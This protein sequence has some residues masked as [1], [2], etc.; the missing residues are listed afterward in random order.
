MSAWP[1][2]DER[3]GPAWPAR[4]AYVPRLPVRALHRRANGAGRVV[5]LS[6]L[7]MTVAC[8]GGWPSGPAE[9]RMPQLLR[10]PVA[11][12]VIDAGGGVADVRFVDL[13]TDA[14]RDM[15]AWIHGALARG[16]AGAPPT[17]PPVVE[18]VNDA[19]RIARIVGVLAE[20]SAPA[21]VLVDA[22]G[23]RRHSVQ[24]RWDPRGALLVAEPVPAGRARV[25]SF[26][27][28][29][30]YAFE[31]T[32]AAAP[33]QI[34][35][36]RRRQTRRV[37]VP[38]H[39]RVK[40]SGVPWP[41]DRI[42]RTVRDISIGGLGFVTDPVADLVFPGIDLEL[43][44]C[45]RGGTPV[46]CRGIVR[47]V[48]TSPESGVGALCG[49][50][51]LREPG[52]DGWARVVDELLHPTTQWGTA[53]PDDLWKVYEGSGYFEL[54]GKTSDE[55]VD[56]RDSFFTTNAVLSDAPQIGGRFALH[57]R[58]GLEA[59]IS[60]LEVWD[61]SWLV[62]QL[63]RLEHNRALVGES[64]HVLADLY[65]HAYEHLQTFAKPEY[66]VT[67]V[68]DVARWSRRMHLQLVERHVESG[69]G[70]IVPFRALE[71]ATK[72]RLPVP[73][74]ITVGPA[75]SAEL[76]AMAEHLARTRHP[77]ERAALG[78]QR[79]ERD[80]LP[81]V[82]RWQA[83][84]LDRRREIIV[85]RRDDQMVAFAILEAAEAGL[86]LFCLTDCVRLFHLGER[87]QDGELALLGAARTW[88]ACHGH[89]RFVVYAD[90]L[91]PAA[92]AEHARDLGLAYITILTAE[93]LP[94]LLEHV[95]E[96]TANLRR[97]PQHDAPR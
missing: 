24:A 20:R 23:G 29:S 18:T 57:T 43:E 88:Y 63:G 9:I 4:F 5:R 84:G 85:A 96:L 69:H 34:V 19:R 83:A 47:H 87:D 13:E 71:M 60:Q 55:F 39:V 1:I 27:P 48:T 74:E 68:Q 82:E 17:R 22:K 61:N 38:G 75:T 46:R 94:E 26:G 52:P 8:E 91:M 78:L 72:T 15:L 53:K 64:D 2:H 93:H 11:A 40:V 97:T 77:L 90:P 95:T 37:R 76:V 41:A 79:P 6:P 65:V 14:A 66:L 10:G 21:R 32:G 80:L 49:V 16:E 86:H 44:L 81:L 45:W 89:H 50:E 36:L 59:T 25:E 7:G 67:L 31:G 3:D 58:R 62:Y 70:V 12:H 51:I 33:E 35:R 56:Y 92:W 54:S 30:V 73:R 28:W 42:E